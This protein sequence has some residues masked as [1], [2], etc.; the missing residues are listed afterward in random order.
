M[1]ERTTALTSSS[2]SDEPGVWC[3][4]RP[5]YIRRS[6][7]QPQDL[8]NPMY[9]IDTETSSSKIHLYDAI[10]VRDTAYLKLKQI[11]AKLRFLKGFGRHERGLEHF[12]SNYRL[13]FELQMPNR[14]IRPDISN[15]Q[16]NGNGTETLLSVPPALE[17]SAQAAED[18]HVDFGSGNFG[19]DQ[20]YPQ[21]GEGSKTQ[22]YPRH[23]GEL[24]F[25]GTPQATPGQVRGTLWR[26]R[27]EA[28]PESSTRLEFLRN[29]PMR[30]DMALSVFCAY[31]HSP[32]LC[33]L[34]SPCPES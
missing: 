27:D 33:R 18:H 23:N 28:S 21:W 6:S 32:V 1:C 3:K 34:F 24:G 29:L 22:L 11:F 2:K 14:E 31:E 9:G 7:Y 15:S 16:G 13:Y 20:V 25:S 17:S 8:L 26:H 5:M 4:L 30:I 12:H 10:V 19:K